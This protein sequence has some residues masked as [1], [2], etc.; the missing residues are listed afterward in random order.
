MGDVPGQVRLQHM[1]GL[2]VEAGTRVTEMLVVRYKGDA[3]AAVDDA[4]R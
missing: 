2:G 3:E 1:R 4:A